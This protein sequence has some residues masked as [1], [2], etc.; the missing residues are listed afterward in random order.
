MSRKLVV[1]DIVSKTSTS[2]TCHDVGDVEM[3]ATTHRRRCVAVVMS[4][5][6]NTSR[7]HY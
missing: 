1:H 2:V 3:V 6:D 5:K 4:K 7:K